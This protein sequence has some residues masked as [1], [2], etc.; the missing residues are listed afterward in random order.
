MVASEV[1]NLAQ[2]SSAA[3]KEIKQLIDASAMHVED[4]L[5]RVYA[6]G[7]T[8]NKVNASIR[9]VSGI[10]DRIAGASA[11]QLSGM[12]TVDHALVQ[13]DGITQQNA[14]LVEQAAAAALSLE[15]Q[16]RYLEQAV[17]AFR[18]GVPAL[19]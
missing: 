18:V 10:V 8:V 1:R 3:A 15:D 7:T 14:A 2:R 11:N 4:G 9:E 5:R 17:A 12:E 13:M 19:Q 6:L 16:A